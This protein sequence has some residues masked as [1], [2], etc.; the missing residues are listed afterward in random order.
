MGD[1]KTTRVPPETVFPEIV[2]PVAVSNQAVR[3]FR[4]DAE[5]STEIRPPDGE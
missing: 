3:R 2:R 4:L 5:R 1:V